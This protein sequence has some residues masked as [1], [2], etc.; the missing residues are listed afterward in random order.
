MPTLQ[1]YQK[2]LFSD[3]V[4]QRTDD[5]EEMGI[6]STMGVDDTFDEEKHAYVLTFPWNFEEVIQEFDT[7]SKVGGYWETFM[8][9]SRAV[10]D[11]NNLF[12]EFHQ[13][14][15]IPD[16]TALQ[17]ICEPALADYVGESLK[18]IHYHGLD[19]EM[20]NMTME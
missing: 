8:H 10:I 7:S 19:V 17:Q 1:V 12:R 5:T 14:S 11:F 20:A 13:A 15:A 3:A 9:N 18:R 16:Y 6:D 4:L 2:R